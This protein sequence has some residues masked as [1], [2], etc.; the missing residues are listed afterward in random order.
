M[1][2]EQAA[3]SL[4]R[5]LDLPPSA[6]TVLIWRSEQFS[7]LKV[8]IDDAYAGMLPEIPDAFEGFAVCV[9]RRPSIIAH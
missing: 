6:A 9:E 5:T 4:K 2:M 1:D 8:W 7:G 3:K